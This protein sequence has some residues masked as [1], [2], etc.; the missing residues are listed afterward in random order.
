MECPICV[1]EWS[2]ELYIP[3]VLNCGHTICEVCANEFFAICKIK[4]RICLKFHNFSI[5][6]QHDDSDSSYK[7][8]CIESMSKN[9]SLLS[10][11]D[12]GQ[13][14]KIEENESLEFS[15]C[16]EH[17]LPIHSYTER[18][19]SFLCDICIEGIADYRLAIH[20][21]PEIHD[22]FSN[23]VSEISKNLESQKKESENIGQNYS[24][25]EKNE[26]KRVDEKLANHFLSFYS[27]LEEI[28]T[29]VFNKLDIALAEQNLAYKQQS[30]IRDSKKKF[31]CDL[32]FQLNSI[33]SLEESEL[34]KN[35]ENLENLLKTSDFKPEPTER[36]NILLYTKK[37][38]MTS[39]HDLLN[40]SY[41][42]KILQHKDGWSCERC[43][44]DNLD[45][46]I[47]CV[48]CSA[49][50]PLEAYPNILKNPDMVTS[51]EIDELNERRQIEF[52][53]ISEL[54]KNDIQDKYYLIHAD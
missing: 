29:E 14:A 25:I 19:Y 38:V 27:S 31:I 13:I 26:L 51:Q 45:R 4:C 39:I 48:S 30:D 8:K 53:T 12:V 35:C 41:E 15:L 33:E 3:R 50:K 18:P 43:L 36:L 22:Y 6:R 34:A 28:K 44:K 1:N 20:P 11:K 42:I 9:F 46:I 21:M 54:D 17:N 5:D 47:S 2:S 40:S 49:F 23:I 10:L 16:E 52:E 37:A 7:K 24:K 32:K